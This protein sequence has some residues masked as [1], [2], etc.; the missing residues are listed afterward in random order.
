MHPTDL[1]A[2]LRRLAGPPPSEA[3][4]GRVLAAVGA[5]L[6]QSRVPALDRWLARPAP[7]IAAAAVLLATWGFGLLAEPPARREAGAAAVAG[8]R[9]T[10]EVF[11]RREQALLALLGAREEGGR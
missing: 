1:E 2:R 11:A 9:M 10:P 7:W 3:L 4:R 6:V 8:P 5:A